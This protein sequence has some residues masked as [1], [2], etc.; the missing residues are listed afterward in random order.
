MAP[1]VG[2][3]PAVCQLRRGN[4]SPS[5]RKDVTVTPANEAGD[6]RSGEPADVV[7]GTV[8]SCAGVGKPVSVFFAAP[9]GG[10]G[11]YGDTADLT[12]VL[13]DGALPAQAAAMPAVSVG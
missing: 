1:L 13:P 5:C 9:G 7:R 6:A 3:V 10:G 12:L 11:T 4:V 8:L 2:V